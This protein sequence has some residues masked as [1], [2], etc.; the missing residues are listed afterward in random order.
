MT[1]PFIPLQ[2]PR[3]DCREFIDI[4]MGRSKSHR[5]PL[6]EYIVDDVLMRPILKDLVGIPWVPWSNDREM[7]AR[8]LDAFIAFWYGMG[9]DAV[10]F[11]LS[12]PLPQR[13][14]V[15]PDAA[16][17]SD[18]GRTWPDEHHG[19]ITSWDDFEQYPWPRV[20]DFDFF[21]FE[22][23]NTHLPEGM[24]L[25]ACHGGGVYEHLSWIMS[26]EGLA[27]ALF[28]DVALVKAVADRLGGLMESFYRNLLSLDGL[29]ALFPGDDMGY[30][31]STL[32]SPQVLRQ[33]VLP[34]HKRFA[35]LAHG[36]GV[37]YFLHSCGNILAIVDDLINDVGIDGKHSYEDV[38]IPV[39][40]FQ[41]RYGDRVAVLGGLDLNILSGSIP[42]RVREHVRFLCDTCG[43]R[44]RYAAGS[45]NSVPSYVPVENYLAMIDEVHRFSSIHA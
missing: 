27:T 5:V 29:V 12:L 17:Q 40:E 45:G 6:V 18:K 25:I 38:I 2:Q 23:L 37:P 43:G 20:E 14:T 4:L 42:E 36:R 24:G 9:Y 28:D 34:W 19:M 44:G 26:F 3:P 7:T 32:V 15:I 30:K 31:S 22:Y 13:E 33:Y 8:H 41:A 16:P 1:W 11:E 39:Q 10:R 21:P 35:A